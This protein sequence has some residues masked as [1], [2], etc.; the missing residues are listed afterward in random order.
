MKKI[1]L[2]AICTIVL[3]S[4][5]RV[6]TLQQVES[7]QVTFSDSIKVNY[8]TYGE[9]TQPIVFLHGFGCD[10]NAWQHQFKSFSKDYKM[11]FIDLPGYG[12]SDKPHV[13]YT[14]DFY[15]AAVKTVMDNEQIKKSI[16]VGH[17]LG[18]AVGRQVIFN[19]PELVSKFVD[20]DGVY[21]FYPADSAMTAAYEG[22]A[23]LFSGGNTKEVMINFIKPLFT[24]Q[25]PQ[26]VKDYAMSI[27]PNTPQ[28]IAGST[29][30]NLIQEKY[31][32]NEK[33]TVP[34]LIIAAKSSQIPPDYKDIMQN[35]YSNM[36]YEE[37]DSVGHFIM[38]EQPE[39]F[40]EML[41]KFLSNNK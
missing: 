36:Q 17:S 24:P 15:A 31:W 37:L 41:N 28:Y 32:T 13:E 19:Y 7:K 39:M 23:A 9:G 29:M 2:F 16:I 8:K 1:I 20:V 10:L 18:T 30:H 21:C 5:N 34:S 3:L 40:N 25:T 22:F 4:C 11:V 27:M 26:S 12:Q 14:L 6:E 35:L 33:I 38:M